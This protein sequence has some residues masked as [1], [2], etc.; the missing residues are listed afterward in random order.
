MCIQISIA[1]HCHAKNAHFMLVFSAYSMNAETF[2]VLHNSSVCILMHLP[3]SI[4]F[5]S[6]HF[7]VKR[8]CVRLNQS[9]DNF[10][11]APKHYRS[12]YSEWWKLK[13]REI[14]KKNQKEE[15]PLMFDFFPRC[16]LL[17]P[18]STPQN[19]HSTHVQCTSNTNIHIVCGFS[20]TCFDFTRCFCLYPS[21]IFHGEKSIQPHFFQDARPVSVGLIW[22][23][24]V[25]RR[26]DIFVF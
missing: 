24:G 15:N 20:F 18:H 9:N 6:F 10:I 1:I 19:V 5:T 26:E 14:I 21:A 11:C 23:P 8:S 3:Y 2:D 17:L 22:C 13:L 25:F 12:M 4:A 16:F 7:V